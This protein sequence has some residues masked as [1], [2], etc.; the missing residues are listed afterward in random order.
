MKW[1]DVTRSTEEEHQQF[2]R[3]L[4]GLTFTK[5]EFVKEGPSVV[6]RKAKEVMKQ[7]KSYERSE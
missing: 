6:F 2:M 4:Q 1:K 5:E 7:L 3:A